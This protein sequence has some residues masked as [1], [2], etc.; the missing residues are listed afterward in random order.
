MWCLTY[1]AGYWPPWIPEAEYSSSRRFVT[2]VWRIENWLSWPAWS[3]WWCVCR[4]QRTSL[5][6]TPCFD[7]L[8]PQGHLLRHD[9]RHPERLHDLR[10]ARARVDEDRLGVGAE[11]Q[12]APR[13]HARAD[14]HVAGEHEEARLE[15]DVDQVEHLDL[16]GHW[17]APLVDPLREPNDETL[18]QVVSPATFAS[19][20]VCGRDARRSTR[21][22]SRDARR[23]SADHRRR[24]RH[25]ALREVRGGGR[26]RPDHRLQLGPLPDGRPRL[27]GRAP[28]VRRR[29]RDRGRDGGRGAAGRPRHAG[30]RG[31]ERHR[32]VP[33]DAALSARAPGAR[34]LR[35]AELPDGR[36]D[37]RQL[38]AGARGDRHELQ[39]GGRDDPGRARARPPDD[40]V[41]LRSRG[42]TL[43]GGRR[44]RH[45]R[46]AHEHDH[47]GADRRHE[48]AVASTKRSTGCRRSPTPPTR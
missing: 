44:S 45:R 43:D 42:G 26:G 12:V 30:A 15:L 38:P 22:P 14:A 10:M 28:R 27:G 39:A 20:I 48:R 8:A 3:M 18:H 5:I 25:G 32:P 6:L 9:A 47:E 19:P 4:I 16:V 13:L 29:E 24:R 11:D 36:R 40:A 2:T 7:E 33:L 31:G 41:R 21:T 1:S 46:R 35:R 37:R 17:M 34:L 23:R